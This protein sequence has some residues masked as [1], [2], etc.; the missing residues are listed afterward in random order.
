VAVHSPGLVTQQTTTNNNEPNNTNNKNY[1]TK[2]P[3]KTERLRC[4]FLELGGFSVFDRAPGRA[5]NRGGMATGLRRNNVKWNGNNHN[6]TVWQ[7]QQ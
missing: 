1:N 2:R 4:R 5:G 3:S 7:Q 6:Q